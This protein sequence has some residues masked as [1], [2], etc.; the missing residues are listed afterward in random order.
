M[1]IGGSFA[2]DD[3]NRA[4]AM[5]P[6]VMSL[7][8]SVSAEF[9]ESEADDAHVSL[10]VHLDG[11]DLN[12]VEHNGRSRFEVEAVA[13]IYDDQGKPVKTLTVSVLVRPGHLERLTKPFSVCYQWGPRR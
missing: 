11:N 5:L 13:V 2:T 8:V 12:Y 10:F 7:G 9:L 6:P 3:L 1:D 4:I